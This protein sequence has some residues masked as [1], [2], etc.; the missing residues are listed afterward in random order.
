MPDSACLAP[1]CHADMP[2]NKAVKFLTVTFP[3]ESHLA[4]DRARD[5]APLRLLPRVL[6]GGG[7][8]QVDPK[9]CFLCHFKGQTPGRHGGG[10][11]SLPRRARAA[12]RSTAGFSFDMKA[13]VDSGVACSRCHLSVHEGTGGVPKDKCYSCH[14]S[15]VEKIGEPE[16]LHDKHVGQKQVRC[17][18][19]HEP[20]RHGNIKLISVMDV[21]CESCHA[22]MH[23]GSEGDVPRRGRQGSHLDPQP[24]VRR[25]DQLHGLPHAGHDPGRRVLPGAGHGRGRPEGLRGLPRRP[26]RPHGGALEGAGEDPCRRGPPH[27]RRGR[28]ARR[29]ELPPAPTPPK[30]LAAGS[31]IQRQIP[32]D[33]PPRPQHRVRHQGPPGQLD[34]PQEARR[35]LGDQGAARSR[36]PSP[37]DAL[38]LL[39]ESCHTFI[40][41]ARSPTTGR[42]WTC[43]TPTMSRR[44]G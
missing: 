24:H 31:R 18:E 28:A 25:A 30:Q 15:R 19:C 16:M 5:Q 42:A 32:G 20:I 8:R 1:G 40:P 39:P 7:P 10:L 11:R 35:S 14:V 36:R 29:A 13:Y 23:G 43:P 9:V 41:R 38:L 22:N 37:R 4:K 34:P 12:S 3:H 17:L 2:K 44:R 6:P 21:S 33:G 26:L 27:G